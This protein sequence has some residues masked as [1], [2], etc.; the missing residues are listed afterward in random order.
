MK[1][2]NAIA[3]EDLC[4][5]QVK[6]QIRKINQTDWR[7][8]KSG[9]KREIWEIRRDAKEQEA[10]FERRGSSLGKLAKSSYGDNTAVTWSSTKWQYL[11][12]TRPSGTIGRRYGTEKPTKFPK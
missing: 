11:M 1:K 8:P 10:V 3:E 5:V 4:S 12:C 7:K 9:I 2:H 6:E